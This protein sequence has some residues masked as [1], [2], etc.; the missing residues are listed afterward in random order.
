MDTASFKLDPILEKDTVEI[1][2]LEVCRVLLMRDKTYPWVILV[3][4]LSGLRD[5]DDLSP[6]ERTQVMAEIDRVSKTMKAVF[7]PYKMNVAALG[8][9]VEQ[10]HIH[11]IAR[12]QGDPAWPGPVWG[13]HPATDYDEDTRQH[14]IREIYAGLV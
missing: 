8:N 12:F 7:E 14:V 11:I 4:A 9:V 13:V 6:S 10:L 3:P 1:A 2:R 5:L